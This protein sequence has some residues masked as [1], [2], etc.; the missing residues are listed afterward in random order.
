MKSLKIIL[1][2]LLVLSTVVIA[3]RAVPTT[4]DHVEFDDIELKLDSVNRVSIERGNEYEVEVRLTPT[5]DLDNVEVEA[6][7][8]GYEYSSI[9]DTTPVF[10]ADANVTYIKRLHLEIPDDM[11]E[12][13]YKLRIEVSDR[14]HTSTI[15]TYNLKIDVPR[16][17]V[18]IDDLLLTPGSTIKAG[19]ALLASVRV[20]N[21]GEKDETDV[22]VTFTIPEIG[23]SGSEYID[24]IDNDDSEETE[25][26]YLRIPRGTEAGTYKAIVEVE[27][28][29][30]HMKETAE[31]V[32]NVLADETYAQQTT[33]EKVSIGLSATLQ[34]VMPGNT[35]VFPIT[36]ENE[37]RNSKSFTITPPQVDWAKVSVTPSSAIIVE[38]GKV[39]TVFINVDTNEDV[40]AGSHTL[41]ALVATGDAQEELTFTTQVETSKDVPVKGV[42][43]ITL[44]VLI[45]IL[46]LLGI[47]IGIAK[48]RDKDEPQK[49]Y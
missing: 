25:D 41:T 40:P 5:E 17:A 42:L 36:I 22:K 19:S 11:D 15:A 34:N 2:F 38:A 44:A 35:A 23:V 32:I 28:D 31:T 10:D 9:S 4:I 30:K 7:I 37:G 39:K 49:Y 6:S 3:A 43:E 26:I 27:Y 47:G 8:K 45:I 21:Q 14:D 16:H 20:E 1:A 13:A 33:E 12:D 46:I 48:M 29:G 24:E 18:V